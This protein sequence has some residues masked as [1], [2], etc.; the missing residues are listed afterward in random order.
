MV[1]L[2]VTV[3]LANSFSVSISFKI[4]NRHFCSFIIKSCNWF[5]VAKVV[6]I[7]FVDIEGEDVF[8]ERF[9]FGLVVV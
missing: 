5:A 3:A 2:G 4:C 1:V 9:M 7:V 8:V 6:V